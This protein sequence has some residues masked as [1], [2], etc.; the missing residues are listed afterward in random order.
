MSMGDL[1]ED[2]AAENPRHAAGQAMLKE[3]LG[4]VLKLLT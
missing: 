1:I 2:K 3:R 4:H